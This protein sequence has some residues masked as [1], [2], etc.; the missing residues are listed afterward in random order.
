M[1]DEG[2][3]M[4]EACDKAWTAERKDGFC[5]MSFGRLCGGGGGCCSRPVSRQ[6]RLASRECVLGLKN[7]SIKET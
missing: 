4:E 5:L 6:G 2:P 3:G 7:V 1:Y